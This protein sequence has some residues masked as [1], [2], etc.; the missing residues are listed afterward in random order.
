MVER[1][2]GLNPGEFLD[3][4]QVIAVKEKRSTTF[5]DGRPG[6]DCYY[7]FM[8]RNCHMVQSRKETP[9]KVCR[10]KLTKDK[11]DRWYVNFRDFL[12][13]KDLINKPNTQVLF[14]MLIKQDSVSKFCRKSHKPYQECP[15]PPDSTCVWRAKQTAANCNVL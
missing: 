7:G 8:A 13:S 14:G 11:T 15:T 4:I 12:I 5:K 9:L 2:I 3:F 1:G 10:A 6:H